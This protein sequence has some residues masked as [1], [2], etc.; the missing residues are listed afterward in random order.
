MVLL[1]VLQGVAALLFII[2]ALWR[3]WRAFHRR[4]RIRAPI[5]RRACPGD[6]EEL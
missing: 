3:G 5:V 2:A 6:G 1:D 4:W